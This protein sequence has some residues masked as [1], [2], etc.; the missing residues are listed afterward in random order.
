M[1]FAREVKMR[2]SLIVAGAALL[3]AGLPLRAQAPEQ[4]PAREPGAADKPVSVVR[5]VELRGSIDFGRLAEDPATAAEILRMFDSIAAQS[6]ADSA[7]RAQ[8]DGSRAMVMAVMGRRAE[9]AAIIDRIIAR[10]FAQSPPY[11]SAWAAA[12]LLDDA[13]RMTALVEAAAR[14]VPPG[15]RGELHSAFDS[16]SVWALIRWFWEQGDE[17]SRVR[18]YEALVEIGWPGD[19]DPDSRDNLRLGLVDARLGRGDLAGA[20]LLARSISAPAQLLRILTVKTYAGLLPDSEDEAGLMRRAV[21]GQ[22]GISARALAEHPDDVQ[23]IF[24]RVQLLLSIGRAAE[25]L[26]LLQPWLGDVRAT[27]VSDA[28]GMWLFD[29]AAYALLALGRAD[30]G[31]AIYARL[32]ALPVAEQPALLDPNINYASYLWQAG[33]YREAL[34]HAERLVRDFDRRMN[35]F[36]RLWTWSAAACALAGL[37]R[38]AEARLWLE[39]MRPIAGANPGALMRGYLCVGD[40]AAAEA[41]LLE[42]LGSDSPTDAVLA[43]QDWQVPE[44]PEGPAVAVEARLAELRARPAVAQALGRVGRV[45]SLPMGRS[46]WGSF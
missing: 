19:S 36:G 10:G 23:A 26:A 22:D 18:L 2:A 38:T 15:Q 13:R 6:P 32:I 28:Q 46:Y 16:G 9:A 21:A 43:L 8:A 40:L 7:E 44:A 11:G 35:D 37:D 14:N 5:N 34:A 39:R 31:A 17:R 29:Q 33:R 41:M 1:M 45:M 4:P 12:A 42:R 30:E 27:V 25:A 24:K 3:L 20:R